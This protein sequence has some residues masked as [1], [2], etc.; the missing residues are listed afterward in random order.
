M[1]QLE[2]ILLNDIYTFVFHKGMD[3]FDGIK[4]FTDHCNDI[5][6]LQFWTNKLISSK[7]GN[8]LKNK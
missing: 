4:S 5:P 7:I 3:I 8:N 6:N 2:N 1:L